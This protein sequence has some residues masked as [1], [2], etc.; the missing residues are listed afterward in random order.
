MYDRRIIEEIFPVREVSTESAREKNIRHGHI[1][2]LHIWWARR[3]LAASRATAYAALVPAPADRESLLQEREFIARLA[4]W[5][6]S[7]DRHLLERA[8]ARIREAHGGQP[9]R[10]LDCFAGG[11]SIPLEAL[12]LG[13]EVY[14]LDYNPVAVL[15]LKAVLEYPQ[16]FGRPGEI[17]RKI[18]TL[19]QTLRE[20]SRVDNVLM[21]AVR[22]WGN[23]VLEK[24]RKELAPFYPPDPDGSVPVG[25]LWA[26]TI[27]CQNPACGAEIPLVRQLW[28]ARKPKRQIALYPEVEGKTV[29]FRVVGTGY[30]AWP[31]GFDPDQGTVAQA[32]ATCLVCGGSVD[33]RAVRKL[34]REGRAGQRMLAVISKATGKTGKRYRIATEADEMAYREAR[35][36]LSS[37]RAALWAAWGIDPL[38]DEPLP[39]EDTLGF[40]VQR[41]GIIRW[42]DLFNARQQLALIT[43]SEYVRKAYERLVAT[44][45][46]PDFAGAVA[47][48]LGL[49]VDRLADYNS[50]LCRW[51]VT[52]EK[53]SNT[54]TRQALPMVWDY[55]ELNPFSGSTGDWTGALEWVTE[56]IG[57]V[58]RAG[59]GATPGAAFIGTAT[60]LPWP[61]GF[62]DAVLTDPPYYDN[63]P[64][65]DLSDLF[66]VW[67]KRTIGHLY[68]ELFIT[69]L[70]PKDQEM[71]S[72]AS[73]AGGLEQAKARFES[74]LAQA[75]SE[76]YRVLKPGGTA[77]IVYAHQTTAGWE[78]LV[79]ALLRSGLAV[80]GSWPINTEMEGRLRAQESAALASSIYIVARKTERRETGFYRDVREELARHLPQR[81]EMLWEEGLS[82]PDLLIA[83]I[84]AGLEVFGKYREVLDY[85]GNPVRADRILDEVRA[86]VADFA[87]RQLLHNGLAS[88]L[89]ELARFYLL[90]RWSFGERQVEFDEARKL[91]QAVGLDLPAQWSRRGSFIRKQREWVRVLGPQDRPPADLESASDLVDVLHRVLL[92]W[93]QGRRAAMVEVLART[94]WG[95]REAFWRFAQAVSAS[96]G[97]HSPSSKEKQL[98]DGLLTG[99]ERLNEQVHERLKQ[100]RLFA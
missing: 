53:V 32:V 99:R 2:T 71:V 24:A 9:P 69:P 25:Y 42:G 76:V 59:L 82:G 44:G 23:W 92:L 67:L 78:T 15:L 80:T 91:A 54:M 100:G 70:T 10:V 58:A 27:P 43:F 6:N 94:G 30:D 4:K 68:P 7:H 34:F 13:C 98:L 35:N 38:P 86:L 11:G 52:G 37:R 96:L 50:T 5:E 79:N 48:Y 3:P 45:A 26:R 63:V 22:E 47:S 17:E 90:Y 81:L 88:E 18:E 8:R 31:K 87:I 12:R 56:V 73:K 36:A 77:V 21:E 62:F 64:Y 49:L 74:L 72:D 29:H 75:M 39:P 14:A 60:E 85:E 93:E 57:H 61:D 55:L 28:L 66:Y 65:G 46:P 40:R 89:S 1:S 84:G 95:A 83:G 51:H 16:R 97:Q 33:D 19:G 41:Y 20:K